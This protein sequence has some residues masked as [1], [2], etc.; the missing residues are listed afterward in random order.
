M[1]ERT[2]IGID[3][4]KTG[5][6]CVW[7]WNSNPEKEKVHFVDWPKDDNPLSLVSRLDDFICD[8]EE[9]GM[10]DN[11]ADWVWNVNPF[12]VIE[13]VSSMPGQGVRSMFSFGKNFGMWLMFLSVHGIRHHLLTPV[14][15]RK[16]LVT[17]TDGP[18]TKSANCTV[19]CRLFPSLTKQLKG[20]RGGL[21]DGRIDALLM[22]YKAKQIE[23]GGK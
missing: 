2:Y 19:A 12:C 11:C 23:I 7:T 1:T 5:A 20:P 13:K 14:A 17:K 4:G 6:M 22:A 21:K 16:N 8:D 3:P 10:F 18:D 9:Y 15:W